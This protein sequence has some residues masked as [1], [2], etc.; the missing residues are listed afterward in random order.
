M[1]QFPR[2]IASRY[3]VLGTRRRW[4][5]FVP[6]L[7]LVGLLLV[8]WGFGYWLYHGRS[9][10]VQQWRG[11]YGAAVMIVRA[12]LQLLVVV[13]GFVTLLVR[14]L[15]IFTSINITGLFLASAAMVIVLSVMSGFE[16]DLKR[17]ILGNNA[18]IVV[19]RPD[20]PFTD[21]A[22]L[23]DQF[24]KVKG[25]VGATP[26][27]TN[28][29]MISSQ[30]NLSGVVVKGI[31]PAT[32]GGVTDLVR[33]TDIGGLEYLISPEKLRGVS[34]PPIFRDD[35]SKDKTDRSDK[36]QKSDKAEKSKADATP[37]AAAAD[38]PDKADK[39]DKAGEKLPDGALK[40]ERRVVPGVIIG[41][42]LA[43]NLR[44]WL[45]DD[46][47]IVSPFGGI[48]PSGV[49]PKSKPFRVAGIFFSGMFEYDTKYVYISLPEAQ[50]FFNMKGEINGI[51][52]KV[53]DPD[54]TEPIL[55]AL[56]HIAGKGYE[57]RDWKMINRSL[58][59]ALKIEKILMFVMLCFG[60]LVAA[61]S[62]ICNGWML[63]EEKGKEIAILKSMGASD[64]SVLIAFMMLGLII[65]GI[66]TVTGLS[67][68]IAVCWALGRFGLP[69]N[70]DVYYI[71]TLPVKMNPYE[72]ALVF[73]SALAIALLATLYPAW[74]ASRLRP[75]DGLRR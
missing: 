69:L 30:T 32:V 48:G 72:I 31:D 74:T 67:I 17:K 37:K 4:T 63:V 24:A 39:A 40:F 28:E 70:S 38:N 49:I 73:A 20:Q 26:Y 11:D 51:E 55:A 42:E 64:R 1:L 41:R 22:A 59:S 54:G 47:N 61:F 43:K 15:T 33:N 5:V 75:V 27:V 25:V 10:R 23:R 52:L 18:H 58:F 65:G 6:V 68:G 56:E 29:V 9:M 8:T 7:V 16:S 14:R 35:D 46:V 36:A 19:T 45:G 53:A 66:G 3:F 50:K 2:L 21:Y 34:G 57:V 13:V 44:L 60:I 62:I 12:I 71:T